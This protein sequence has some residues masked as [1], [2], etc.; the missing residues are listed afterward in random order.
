MSRLSLGRWRLPVLLILLSLLPIGASVYRIV[1]LA[2]TDV[3]SVTSA[4][5]L[6][7]F[8]M[9]TSILLHVIFAITFLALGAFQFVPHLRVGAPSLHKIIG[10]L[11]ALSGVIFAMSGVYMVFAYPSHSQGNVLIDFGRVLFGSA[12][13]VFIGLGILAAVLRDLAAHRAWMIRSYALAASSGI[14]SYFIAFAFAING[15]FDAK[16]ADAMMWLGWAVGIFAAE[17]I[18]KGNVPLKRRLRLS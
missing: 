16:L 2:S 5:E 9:P 3:A 10:Y 7:F 12:I 13:P 18:I 15:G 17:R 11:A 6:R 4:D 14:Q 1:V 8:E